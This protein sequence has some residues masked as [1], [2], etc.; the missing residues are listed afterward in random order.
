MHMLRITPSTE[1]GSNVYHLVCFVSIYS[2]VL[3][4]EVPFAWIMYQVAII[5][6]R[7]QLLRVGND[8]SVTVNALH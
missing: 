6:I 1:A 2:M 7:T 3:V 4:M 8:V 5:G